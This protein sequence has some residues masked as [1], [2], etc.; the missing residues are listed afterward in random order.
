MILCGCVSENNLPVRDARPLRLRMWGKRPNVHFTFEDMLRG[1]FGRVPDPFVD[2][3]DIAVYVYCA[4]QAVPR[5]EP[6]DRNFGEDWRRRLFFR[7]PVREPARWND[8]ETQRLLVAALSFLTEDEYDFRFE[9]LREEEPTQ[10][11]FRF[12]SP[13]APGGGPRRRSSFTRADSTRWAAPSRRRWS[14]D[15][16]SA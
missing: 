5:G 16:R 4:D 3:I 12:T 15:A 11:Y 8:S 7:L 13:T 2:L 1:M 6:T 10:N 14:T 9:P